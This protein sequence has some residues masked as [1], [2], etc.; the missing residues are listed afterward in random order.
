MQTGQDADRAK[1]CRRRPDRV[2]RGALQPGGGPV[3]QSPRQHDQQRPYAG[4]QRPGHGAGEEPQRQDVPEEVR[5]V[6]VE[7]ER[8]HH[9]P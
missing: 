8:G 2:V 3:R 5:T 4:S 7:T 9:P 1:D 6:D